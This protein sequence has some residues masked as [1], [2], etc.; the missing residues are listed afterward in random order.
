MKWTIALLFAVSICAA[1]ENHNR[2][3]PEEQRAGWKLLFD[4]HTMNG[5]VDPRQHTPPGDAW[6]IDDGALKAQ[7]HAHITED[8]F[9]KQR[10]RDFE[11]RW[12]W[13]L[14][15][16]VNS[17]LK[18]RIQ[19]HIYVEAP[20]TVR[21]FEQRVDYAVAHPT[22]TRPSHGQD[23]VIG[24]EYQLID[25]TNSDAK[26][27]PL[28]QTGAL[29]DMLPPTSIPMKPSGEW[30]ESR[31]VLRGTHFEH[32]LNGEKVVEGDLTAPEVRAHI[33]KRWGDNSP[34]YNLLA[35]EPHKDCPISLQNHGGAAWFRDIRIRELK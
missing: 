23:Y 14:G 15:P 16:G 26:N 30:N 4:G 18:Y 1:Q 11:L 8:L 13:K 29:Y 22:T 25:G 10:F 33:A 2:L 9:T 24:F 21:R 6:T 28:H 7:P 32:W 27:G 34:V 17:G 35:K 12:Q 5:W 3:T 31:I 20:P 19:D